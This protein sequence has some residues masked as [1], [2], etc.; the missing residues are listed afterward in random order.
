MTRMPDDIGA[1]R[2]ADRQGAEDPLGHAP[3]SVCRG[4]ERNPDHLLERLTT[5]DLPIDAAGSTA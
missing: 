1:R 3:H 5:P 2:L 4:D